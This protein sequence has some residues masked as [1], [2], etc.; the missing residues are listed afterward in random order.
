LEI[1]SEAY[2][3]LPDSNWGHRAQKVC[4]I[5]YLFA[6]PPDE[7]DIDSHQKIVHRRLDR[8]E[9]VIAR[10]RALGGDPV[11]ARSRFTPEEDKEE[12]EDETRQEELLQRLLAQKRQLLRTKDEVEHRMEANGGEEPQEDDV[13]TL[14]RV[15]RLINI[16]TKIDN[17]T[18]L[19]YVTKRELM[20]RQVA[21]PLDADHKEEDFLEGGEV[22]EEEEDSFHDV[23]NGLI[24]SPL[25]RS[26]WIGYLLVMAAQTCLPGLQETSMDPAQKASMDL[27][28]L[29]RQPPSR[30]AKRKVDASAIPYS[31]GAAISNII[32]ENQYN[33][34]LRRNKRGRSS[35]D[36]DHSD[37]ASDKSCVHTLT[38]ADWAFL[39]SAYGCSNVPGRSQRDLAANFIGNL[40]SS[41]QSFLEPANCC[42]IA[43]LDRSRSSSFGR[44][45]V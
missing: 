6:P 20:A 9:A 36:S 8:N 37:S 24:S 40:D 26:D 13:R 15:T 44:T 7:A 16:I 11:E 5:K 42:K 4:F 31:L 32:L 28:I 22:L 3:R 21:A 27:E 2:C 33:A 39:L 14:K 29:A 35:F 17:H 25:K 30:G 1:L 10:I 19:K 12:T 34:E 18:F 38:K 41:T 43:K 45:A 23:D